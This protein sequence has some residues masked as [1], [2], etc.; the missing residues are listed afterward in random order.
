MGLKREDGE[1]VY[2]QSDSPCRKC[3]GSLRFR[4]TVFKGRCAQCVSAEEL[5]NWAKRWLRTTPDPE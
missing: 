4:N 2:Y 1:P 3:N 5:D